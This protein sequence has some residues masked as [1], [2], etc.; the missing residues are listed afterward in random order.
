LASLL[1]AALVAL[2]LAC[3]ACKATNWSPAHPPTTPDGRPEGS[4]GD[5]GGGGGGGMM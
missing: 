2:V 1:K 5:N 3:C 4:G